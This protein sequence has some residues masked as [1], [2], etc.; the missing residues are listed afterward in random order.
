[1][2]LFGPIDRTL[3][4]TK[5]RGPKITATRFSTLSKQNLRLNSRHIRDWT[6]IDHGTQQCVPYAGASATKLCLDLVENSVNMGFSGTGFPTGIIALEVLRIL[7]TIYVLSLIQE[8]L[9]T[10]EGSIAVQ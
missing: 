7:T 3:N 4:Q 2:K 8:H 6:N 1:M 10:P 9:L 5:R